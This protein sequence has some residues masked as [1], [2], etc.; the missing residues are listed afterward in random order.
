MICQRDSA[1]ILDYHPSRHNIIDVQVD[2]R[3]SY[4]LAL[5]RLMHFL[6]LPVHHTLS[7]IHHSLTPPSPV[8]IDPP[9][10]G[11]VIRQSFGRFSAKAD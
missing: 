11:F 8:T 2:G 7:T 10:L 4:H 6:M 9:F 1:V 5:S 3:A